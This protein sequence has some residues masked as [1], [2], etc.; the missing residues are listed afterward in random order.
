MYRYRRMW[1]DNCLALYKGVSNEL[2]RDLCKGSQ[3]KTEHT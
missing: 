1:Y 3:L 2:E